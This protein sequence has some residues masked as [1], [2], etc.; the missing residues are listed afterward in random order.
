VTTDGEQIRSAIATYA[1][2]SDASDGKTLQAL[3][4][5]DGE[6]VEHGVPIPALRLAE[7]ISFREGLKANRPQPSGS[8]H[9]QTNTS[10]TFIRPDFATASTDLVM[11]DLDPVSGWRV[12]AVGRYSDEFVRDNEM[13]LFKRR[14]MRWF[15]DL[16]RNPLV[17]EDGAA[18]KAHQAFIE[19]DHPE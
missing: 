16:G 4:A 6:L 10:I 8:I 17:G 2:A 1:H 5:V 13:W 14:E 3:F 9:L 7:C 11:I 19:Q 15:R 12:G 18:A